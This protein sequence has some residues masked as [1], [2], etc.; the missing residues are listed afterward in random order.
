MGYITG[1]CN[2]FNEIKSAFIDLCI[3]AGWS[4]TTDSNGKTVIYKESEGLYMMAEVGA[5]SSSPS[6]P[7]C[8]RILGRTS[9][10]GGSAPTMVGISNMYSADGRPTPGAIAFPVIYYGFYYSNVNEVYFIIKYNQMYQFIAFGKSPIQVPGTGFWVAG[11]GGIPADSGPYTYRLRPSSIG[12]S[13]NGSTRYNYFG[14]V[15]PAIFWCGNRYQT[16]SSTIFP[17]LNCWVHSNLETAYPWSLSSGGNAG[18][19][20]GVRY[21]TLH[22]QAQPQQFNKEA[23][24]LP[25]LAY[26]ESNLYSGYYHLVASV[27]NARHIKINYLDPETIL[28]KDGDQWVVFPCFKKIYKNEYWTATDDFDVESGNFGWA[29]KKEA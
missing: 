2:S 25:I 3:T 28:N 19:R 23:L 4:Q 27:V 1:L 22:L 14:P 24:L 7:D 17:D 10:N 16:G 5:L 15:P 21:L 13:V 18:Q 9:V 26:K 12:M 20:V 6:T 11:T 8:F 29:V